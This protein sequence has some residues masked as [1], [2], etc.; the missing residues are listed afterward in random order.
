MANIVYFIMFVLS[1]LNI[2]LLSVVVKQQRC[3]YYVTF[4]MLISISCFGYI[5]IANA[6]T[7]PVALLGNILTYL[8]ACFLPYCF[9]LC[10]SELCQLPLKRWLSL[11]MFTYNTVVFF[12]V[13]ITLDGSRLY[14]AGMELQQKDGITILY[15]QSGPLRF[16]YEISVVF[17]ALAAVGVLL[18]AFRSRK[19]ISYKNLW[20]LTGLEL[21]TVI[22]YAF[23]K[24]ANHTVDWVCLAYILDEF[25]LLVLIYRIGKYDVSESIAGSINGQEDY[26]YMIFDLKLNYLGCSPMLKKY[27]PDITH[28]KVDRQIEAKGNKTIEKAV[29]WLTSCTITG[30]REPLYIKSKGRD[31]KCTWRP[32]N[33]GLFGR[34]SGY[35]VEL[36]DD[37]NQQKYLSLIS[38]YNT[39]LEGEVAAKLEHIQEMQDQIIIGISDIVESRDNSTGGHVKRTSEAVRIFMEQLSKESA[40]FH[41]TKRYCEN[42]IK[43]APM[44]DLGK[45]AVEDQILRKPGRFTEEEYNLMKVHAAVGAQIVEKAL[46]GV[47]DAGFMEVAKNMAHYHHEKWNGKGYPEGLAGEK[48]PLEARIMA[49]ADVFDALVS[50]RCY[51][52]EY[53]Y[54]EAF[55]IIEESLGSH[56]DPELGK[57]FMNCRPE[58]EAYY[59][60]IGK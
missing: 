11:L 21:V 17:Y 13:W 27:F 52:D 44:H 2:V 35:L 14:Y 55:R 22:I 38:N 10:I 19:N 16:L 31:L 41:M 57:I 39:Q 42:V 34:K 5:T 60:Q 20:M 47:E 33:N 36:F 59:N 32:I 25:I 1:V 23:E 30:I 28:V 54:D 50:K 51:K 9:L 7:L 43:A 24:L 8:G 48:I 40:E 37:T 29:A 6:G 45:I 26:A 49:L 53:S 46:N 18:H 56:F 3:F 12:L 4:F 58:L 15:T